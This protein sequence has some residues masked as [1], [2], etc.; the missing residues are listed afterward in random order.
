[1]EDLRAM[2]D[3]GWVHCD[4]CMFGQTA[5]FKGVEKPALKPTIFLS[6]C[7]GVL[8]ALNVRC[9]HSHEHISLIGG[10]AKQCE[11]YTDQLVRAFLQGLSK[12]LAMDHMHRY[13]YGD[14][15]AAA[16]DNADKGL[17]A[18]DIG[19]KFFIWDTGSG[20]DLIS[21]EIAAMH[22]GYTVDAP[23]ILTYRFF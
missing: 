5:I 2:P 7:P 6:N 8:E 10:L 4:Q 9:D 17:M 23:P 14:T 13:N 16:C 20:R 18:M 21:E 11:A 19:Q 12:Q 1:M 3:V 22:H 15:A